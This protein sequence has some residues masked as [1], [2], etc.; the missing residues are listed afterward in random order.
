MIELLT[1]LAV[2]IVLAGL[3]LPSL[4]A[5]QGKAKRLHCTSNLRQLGVALQTY[6]GENNA[7]PVAMTTNGLGN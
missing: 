3:L 6:I 7:Y 2:V 1:V 5:A 4:V